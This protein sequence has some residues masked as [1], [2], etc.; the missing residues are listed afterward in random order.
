[1]ST[2]PFVIVHMNKAFCQASG[3]AHGDVIGKPVEDILQVDQDVPSP[4]ARGVSPLPLSSRFLVSDGKKCK[5]QVSPITD[6]SQNTR[7][8]THVMVTIENVADNGS[9]SALE[10]LVDKTMSDTES[11]HD[12]LSS[13]NSATTNSQAS[14]KVTIG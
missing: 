1:M 10:K 11:T 13:G 5:I 8:M 3:L 7:G 2:P 12:K 4:D 6:R 14:H 9:I